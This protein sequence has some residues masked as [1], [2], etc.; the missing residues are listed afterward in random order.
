VKKKVL[1]TKSIEDAGEL[2]HYAIQNQIEL[3]YH[4]FL[5]FEQIQIS[6]IPKLEVLF[7]SS[8][9]AVD[10]LLK[11][12]IVPICVEVACIGSATKHYLE[13]RGILVDFVG[14]NSSRPQ[15]VS[16]ELHRWL[17]GRIC[18]LVTAEES[19]RTIASYLD[20]SLISY[21]TPYRTV[22]HDYKLDSPMDVL[23]FTSPSNVKG[24]LQ[25]NEIHHQ[26][27][28]AWGKTTEAYL[29]KCG[30]KNVYCLN[31]STEKEVISYLDTL[32]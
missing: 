2:Q 13:D 27:V 12:Q 6:E 8:K 9:R 21:I 20:E 28:V 22:I 25:K 15:E 4:S 1:I 23:V 31:N 30:F 5:S 7:F 18:G 26:K 19:Q 24:Y 16:K 14:S 11:Q 10:F 29:L 3:I 17:N 32:N